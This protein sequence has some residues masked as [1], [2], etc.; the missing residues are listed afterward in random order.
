VKPG[1]SFWTAGLIVA[2]AG[3]GG[4][5]AAPAL[6][7]VQHVFEPTLSLTGDCTTSSVDPV[8]DPGCPGGAHPPKPFNDACGAATDRLGYIYVASGVDHLSQHEDR[9]DVFS[10]EGGFVTEIDTGAEGLKLACRLAVDS[11]GRIYVNA[12]GIG[13][14]SRIARFTPKTYPPAAEEEAYGAAEPFGAEGAV[15]GVAIDPANDRV[16][17]A[18]G[19]VL[20]Y[21]PEGVLSSEIGSSAF[22]VDVRSETHEIYV[23]AGEEGKPVVRIYDGGDGH[24][25]AQV[26]TAAIP[27]SGETAD[28]FPSITVDQANGDFYL[29]DYQHHRIYQF[30]RLGENLSGEPEFAKVTPPIEHSLQ[31]A[32]DGSDIAFDSSL[33]S[34]NQAYLF[35]TSGEVAGAHLYAFKPLE[36]GP[37]LISDEAASQISTDTATLEGKVAPNGAPT[38]Y[39]FQYV[40]EA[41]FEAEGWGGATSL[42]EGEVAAEAPATSV[43]APVAG[44][45]PGTLY[46]FRIVATNHCKPPE[47]EECTTEGEREGGEEISRTFATYPAPA[48]PLSCSN[49]ALRTGPS[50]ALPDC[51]AYELVTPS[52]AGGKVPVWLGSLDTQLAT[53]DGRSLLFDTET[54]ALPGTEG[55]GI[56][57]AYQAVR[58]EGV[59]WRS[60]G[61]G[62]SGAQARVPEPISASPDHGYMLWG[63]YGPYGGNLAIPGVFEANYVRRPAGV[64]DSNC[65]PEPQGLFELVG[66]GSEGKDPTAKAVWMSVDAAHLIFVTGLCS[67]CTAIQLEPDAPPTGTTAIYDRGADGVTHVISLLPDD[68]TLAAGENAAYFGASTDG[69]AVAFRIKSRPELYLRVGDAETLTV[70]EDPG[71]AFA[72]VSADGGYVFYLLNGDIFRY[73]TATET[74]SQIG[75]GG[76]STLVNISADGTHVY[77]VSPKK[78]DG[79]KGIEGQPNL[80]VWDGLSARFVATV[81]PTD[82]TGEVALDKWVFETGTV[83]GGPAAHAG[84]ALDPSRTTPDG[85]VLIFESH[86]DLTPPYEGK[87]HSEVYRYD[88]GSGAIACLSCNP[89][90]LPAASNAR[91]QSNHIANP[92]VPLVPAAPVANVTQDGRRVFFESDERLVPRDT[93]GLADVYEWNADG[94]GGCAREAGCL[95]L[96]SSGQSGRPNYLFAATGADVFIRS[97]DSLVAQDTDGGVP[98]IYDA[99]VNGGFSTPAGPSSCLEDAC[100]GHPGGTPNMPAAASAGIAGSGNV[101]PRPKRRCGK[102]RRKV[103]KHGSV[104][105]VKRRHH[106]HGRHSHT[107]RANSHWRTAR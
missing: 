28:P 50:A 2:V 30:K 23:V 63:V 97:A 56:H 71:A 68:K 92:F 78:L 19:A 29:G 14:T 94:I 12:R 4:I 89:T 27:A 49:S 76:E 100:Q 82:F 61:V 58:G 98:S 45:E 60:L 44:L 55:N 33:E 73:D 93:D 51:R 9:I 106:K 99:R 59:G 53:P 1:G 90:G 85:S 6:G 65:S 95:N 20:E 41:S 48:A 54:G 87:G 57:D 101:V 75:S 35:A 66:C 104:R 21:T 7:T 79:A 70:S 91:L 46:H 22:D 18:R 64:I 8:P 26:G 5:F 80:Y 67:G 81:D 52:D 17:I 40:D 62:P 16:Y 102:T 42:G 103:K 107:K 3:W 77:F 37:P 72:G 36:V 38:L 84:S 34:P 96:I 74:T 10:P 69:T 11:T 47:P 31:R 39:R 32:E 105:C 24:L 25:K 13:E 43:A 88:A 83:P 15:S 86:A